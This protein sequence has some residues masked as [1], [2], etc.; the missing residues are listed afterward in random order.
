MLET[1]GVDTFGAHEPKTKSGRSRATKL[2]TK[3]LQRHRLARWGQRPK[4]EEDKRFAVACCFATSVELKTI[5]R[6]TLRSR[7]IYSAFLDEEADILYIKCNLTHPKSHTYTSCQNHWK[8]EEAQDAPIQN[9]E[10][11]GYRLRW[12]ADGE[13]DYVPLE[14]VERDF[15]G[16]TRIESFVFSN[17]SLVM[18]GLTSLDFKNTDFWQFISHF[19][20]GLAWSNSAPAEHSYWD[21]LEYRT[22]DRTVSFP[23]KAS[24]PEKEMVQLMTDGVD[25]KLAIS[26]AMSQSI[27]MEIFEE[28]VDETVR[29]VQ[30]IP[31]EMAQQGVRNS[32]ANMGLDDDVTGKLSDV[33]LV[34]RFAEVHTAIIDV[35]L[36][37]DFLDVPDF[38]W[39][40]DKWQKLWRKFYGYFEIKERIEILN[41]RFAC[42]QELLE[43]LN[44]D[45]KH[46]Q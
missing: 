31:R 3:Q 43:I 42:L 32:L 36:V 30:Q 15:C 8:Q 5:R 39:V 37:H 6:E 17:G 29:N 19:G 7:E 10:P 18:W 22:A 16:E 27:R 34:K 44:A 4:V 28:A 13:I 41:K 46:G 24:N 14:V 38:F 26:L 45:R 1:R 12:G 33:L 40:D 2:Q 11:I 21:W 9:Q 23:K 20:N 35:N 25:E